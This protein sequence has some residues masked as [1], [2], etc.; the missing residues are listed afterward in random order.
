[1][2]NKKQTNKTKALGYIGLGKMGFNMAERL[3]GKGWSI[4]A[5]D[6]NQGA[7]S[8]FGSIGGR[9]V[10]DAKA[11]VNALEA[12]K[13][14]IWI[15]VPHQFVTPVLA[16]V[17]PLLQK[18]D[19]VIDGGNS[20]FQDSVERGD[21]LQKIGVEYIDA[22]V[23]GGP[24]GAKYGAC[25]MVGGDKVAYDSVEH[26]FKDISA[27]DAYKYMGRRGAGHFVKM[28][29]NGIEYGMMEAIAEGFNVMK[30][31]DFDLNMIDIADIYQHK[32]VVESRLVGWLKKGFETYG[33][34]L[35]EVS[36][37]AGS[38]GEGAWT[39]KAAEA[40]GIEAHSVKHALQA[41]LDSQ[42]NPSYGGKL[43][44][45]MRIMFGG[46]RKSKNVS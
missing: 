26:L 46:K 35:V 38:L 16:E 27:K 2:N 5:T 39:I 43:I 40:L 20:P 6:V 1:M 4:T 11:V 3:I 44:Q 28:V 45:T 10:S 34:D 30:A 25:C 13:R 15:M 14:V 36:G 18:G 9:G 8:K 37:S 32:S 29:H 41:R 17:Y 7:V 12:G 23:S 21:H 31:S 24:E 19:I 22:G 33:E 42:K